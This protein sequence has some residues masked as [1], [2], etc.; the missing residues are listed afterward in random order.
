MVTERRFYPQIS[1]LSGEFETHIPTSEPAIASTPKEDLY[2]QLGAIEHSDL[3]DENPDLPLLFMNY[4]F[5][6]ENQPVR[7]LENFNRFPRQIVANLEVWINP[8][9]KFIWA[10]SLLFF[11]SGLLILLPIG[12][13]RP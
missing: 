3:S 6:N 11:F 8:L 2:I 1:H 7:K 13:S 12:E 9:V 5:T 4:L 10:G